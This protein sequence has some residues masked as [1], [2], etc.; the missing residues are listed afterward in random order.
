MAT[1]IKLDTDL[2]S[3]LK[4][5]AQRRDRSPHW[6]MR[7][8]IK[9]YIEREERRETLKEDAL[10]AWS[11]YQETGRHVTAQEADQWLGSLIEGNDE[12]PPECH[13]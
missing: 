10:K 3:R 5:L 7:E 4:L 1:S 9:G 13:S 6:L 12:E 11:Q 2:Q 8:A